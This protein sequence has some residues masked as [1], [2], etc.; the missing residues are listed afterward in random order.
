MKSVSIYDASAAKRKVEKE[1]KAWKYIQDLSNLNAEDLD[2]IAVI[3]GNRKYTYKRMFR[4]WERY[5]AVFSALNMTEEQNSRVGVLGSTCAE[6]IFAFYGLNMVGAQTS[7]VASWKAFNSTQIEETIRQEKL[8]DF[9][10]TD[11]LAQPDLVRELLRKRKELGLNHVIVLH[12]TMA[13]ATAMPVMTASQDFKNVSMKML[14]WPYCMETLLARYG[15]GPVHYAQQE[16]DENALIMHTTGTTSGTGKPV[17]MSDNALNAAVQSFMKIKNISLPFDHLVTA[18]MLDLSNSYGIIDQVHL[19]FAMGATLVTVPLGFLNP[20]FYK[21]ISAY[22]ISFLFSASYM[23][24]RW[25]KMPEDTDFDFSSLKFV[26]LG[27]TAVSAAEKRRYHEFIVSHGGS[28][29][30][31]IL[32]GYGLSE[33]G[34]ACCLSSPALD[35]ESIGY[36]L[37][38]II[39]RLYDEQ[40]G[41]YFSPRG[42]GGEGVLYL[43]SAAMAGYELDGKEVIKVEM[44]DR[45]PYVCTNDLVRMEPDGRI[46][47]LGRAN[48]FFMRDENRKYES[49]RVETEFSRLK[50]INGCAIIP[51]Y[52]KIE[53]DTIPMLCVETVEGSGEPLEVVTNALRQVFIED[54]SLVED[55][56]PSRVMLVEKLPRNTNGKIDLYSLNQGKVSGEIYIV[57]PVREQD[58]LTDF[59]L[60]S[61][62]EDST[63][64]VVEMVIGGI[65]ADIKESAPVKLPM[66]D[67]EEMLDKM[68][69]AADSMPPLPPM[70]PMPELPPMP[71]MPFMPQMPEMPFM[72]PM[73]QMPEM[74]Q[75]PL[76]PMPGGDAWGLPGLN[77]NGMEQ[78]ED[79]KSQMDAFLGQQLEMQKSSMEAVREWCSSLFGFNAN[80]SE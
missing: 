71:Q 30:V 62:E 68:A 61:F 16:T 4:E 44:I 39:I 24:D 22:R 74:P 78:L 65:T 37:P 6:V 72:P 63:S 33:L 19:P 75:M 52:Y 54:K 64:D 46:V 3:D 21:A 11:D 50:D 80:K 69:K 42:K 18:T 1:Q 31:A 25:M 56:I 79:F 38:G 27:G 76:M 40:N 60:T 9:I 35:D 23:F 14:Y 20:W 53:H 66:V 36:A 47:Y 73:P 43:T 8:T 70:P 10:V 58:Q 45:K 59:N 67:L 77:G 29:D 57:N 51:V 7:L 2:K 13:G 28:E 49:G 41:N 15:N 32:N 34:G 12:V 26:A 55:N 48:R 17:P 5:A